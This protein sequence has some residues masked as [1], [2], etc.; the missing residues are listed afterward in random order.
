MTT[1]PRAATRR[2]VPDTFFGG[3]MRGAY[4]L[5]LEVV[6]VDK[7]A[8]HVR[9]VT[10]ASSDL[11][12]FEY[13]PGQDLM[14]EFPGEQRPV[15]RR[16]T[17]RRADPGAGTA[18]L[19]MELHA[20]GGR[21]TTWAA[22]ATVGDRLRAMGPRG[23]ITLR[24]GT[25]PSVFVGDDSAMPAVFALLDALP[26]GTAATAVLV[27]PH[28]AGSRPAPAPDP[29]T[30]IVWADEDRL[31]EVLG[32]L[33]PGARAYVFGERGL[34]GRAVELLG[35]PDPERIAAKAYWRRDQA[36]AAHGEPLGE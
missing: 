13:L 17:I 33:S 16:Y 8:E 6:A 4:L 35:G 14:I 9:S 12:G 15:H 7:L 28:G 31:P 21:A 11:V 30:S 3:R 24:S 32:G 26:P 36:N 10:V 25:S 2:P 23:A 34:V 18:V 1:P 27:T 20:G 29:M 22:R 5:D 19:E